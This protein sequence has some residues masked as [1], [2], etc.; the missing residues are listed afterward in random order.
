MFL[1]RYVCGLNIDGAEVDKTGMSE[2]AE[3]EVRFNPAR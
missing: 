1:H 3:I 2:S